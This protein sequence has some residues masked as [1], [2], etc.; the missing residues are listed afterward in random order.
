MVV[1]AAQSSLGVLL[2]L[3]KLTVWWLTS[4]MNPMIHRRDHMSKAT[5]IARPEKISGDQRVEI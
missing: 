1:V 5:E 2:K 4:Y 3:R